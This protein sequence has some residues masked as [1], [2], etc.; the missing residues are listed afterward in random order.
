[1]NNVKHIIIIRVP[2]LFAVLP[3]CHR[4]ISITYIDQKTNICL[5]LSNFG[6]PLLYLGKSLEMSAFFPPNLPNI[7]P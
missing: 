1:M 4:V 2:M 5:W 3:I 6:F 7:V